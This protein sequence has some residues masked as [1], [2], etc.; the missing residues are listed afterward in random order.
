M[1]HIKI[2]QHMIIVQQIHR[3]IHIKFTQLYLFNFALKIDF[4]T[5]YSDYHLPP[6]TPP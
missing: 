4:Y 2:I 5:L 1:R 6:K 3:Y